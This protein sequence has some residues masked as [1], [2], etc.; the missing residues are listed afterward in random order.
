VQGVAC[1]SGVRKRRDRWLVCLRK[2]QFVSFSCK[3]QYARIMYLFELNFTEE[4]SA[5]G[6]CRMKSEDLL[7]SRDF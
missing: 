1:H 3:I 6:V 5:V 2:K 7:G 4:A